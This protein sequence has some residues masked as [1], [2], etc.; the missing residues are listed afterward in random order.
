MKKLFLSLVVI[1]AYI[2][3]ANAYED[4]MVVVSKQSGAP[5][6]TKHGC[7][8][9]KWQGDNVGCFVLTAEERTIYFGFNSSSVSKKERKKLDKLLKIAGKNKQIKKV[10]IVGFAD[11]VGSDRYN[12]RLSKR[13][14]MT[15]RNYLRK[16][17]K[18]FRKVAEVD[19]EAL[20]E[21]DARSKCAKIKNRKQR[22]ACGKR[23]RR[24]EVRFEF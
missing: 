7:L 24:V 17:S 21:S 1:F 14:A 23:D 5:I 3:N 8:Y 11:S 2:S 15:V 9:T 4:R 6:T 22:I 16:R 10:S 20:G 18:I 13:R 12:K 19:V